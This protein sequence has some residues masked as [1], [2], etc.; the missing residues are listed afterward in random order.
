MPAEL[1]SLCAAMRESV[2]SITL[3]WVQRVQQDPYLRSRN[4]LTLAQ[5]VDHVPQMLEELCELFGEEGEPDFE[6]IRAASEHGYIRAAEGYTLTQLL[7][8]LELLRGC[9]FNFVAETEIKR[10][11]NRP[12]TIQALKLVNKYFGEDIIFVAEHFLKKQNGSDDA[13]A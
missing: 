7:R 8:E 10:G 13:K 2:D 1:E 6:T 3:G 11:V 4:R 12:D 9:L 5:I